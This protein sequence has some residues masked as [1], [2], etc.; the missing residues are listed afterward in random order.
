[1]PKPFTHDE[2]HKIINGFENSTLY[3]HYTDFML[4]LF[5]TGCRIGEAI[6]LRWKHINDDF[7]TVW[8]AE[9]LKPI[10][11]AKSRYNLR[12][13]RVRKNQIAFLAQKNG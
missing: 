5:G 10:L 4:F 7:S 11:C 9:S 12:G 8:I 1:M 2:I 13:F 6:G 3:S